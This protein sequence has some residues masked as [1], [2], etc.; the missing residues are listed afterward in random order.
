MKVLNVVDMDANGRRGSVAEVIMRNTRM[1]ST[2]AIKWSI[3]IGS[4]IKW[5]ILIGSVI[6][7]IRSI[8]I[9]S[10]I[11]PDK[12]SHHYYSHRI[13]NCQKT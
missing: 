1:G 8:L 5:S 4:T 12:K 13:S 2:T 3:L 6:V 7:I 10:A 11:E 9:G